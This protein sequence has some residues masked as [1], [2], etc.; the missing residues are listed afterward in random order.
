MQAGAAFHDL[1]RLL[2][3]QTVTD[4]TCYFVYVSS[5]EMAGYFNNPSN[6][7]DG[8]F[9]LHPGDSLEITSD[10]FTAKPMTFLKALGGEFEARVTSVLSRSLPTQHELRIY[11]VEAL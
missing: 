3:V 11:Q 6:G 5:A 10:Y 7:H 4:A 9:G 2:L 1:H 8:F